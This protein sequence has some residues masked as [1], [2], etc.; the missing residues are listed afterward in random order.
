MENLESAHNV[1]LC[2]GFGYRC[3][4]SPELKAVMELAR[5]DGVVVMEASEGEVV[6]EQDTV[7]SYLG[8]G[9]GDGEIVGEGFAEG[10]IEGGVLRRVW[11]GI[12]RISG[13]TVGVEAAADEAGAGSRRWWSVA[14]KGKQDDAEEALHNAVIASPAGVSKRVFGS[15]ICPWCRFED[16][17]QDACVLFRGCWFGSRAL[18]D[19]VVVDAEGSRGR[20]GLDAC[21]G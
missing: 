21:D 11:A 1:L 5:S 10:E 8:C 3:R 18:N 16:R 13:R 2:A 6:V 9:D 4:L 17:H 14:R 15:R 7:V 19:Q 20:V 12:A